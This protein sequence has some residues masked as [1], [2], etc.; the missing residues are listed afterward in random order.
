MKIFF[1]S[2]NLTASIFSIISYEDEQCMT[3]SDEH[4]STPCRNNATCID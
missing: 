1:R 4:P 2:N 3:E